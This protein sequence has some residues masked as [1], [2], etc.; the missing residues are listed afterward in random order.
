MPISQ[1]NLNKQRNS[2]AYQVFDAES[3]LFIRKIQKNQV[4][5]S[6]FNK[7]FLNLYNFMQEIF[8]KNYQFL[9]KN[10]ISML[11]EYMDNPENYKS[12]SGKSR[13]SSNFASLSSVST[14]CKK[15]CE[16]SADCSL[17]DPLTNCVDSKN[18]EFQERNDDFKRKKWEPKYINTKKVPIPAYKLFKKQKFSYT[19]M[20][21]LKEKYLSSRDFKDKEKSEEIG[22]LR[23]S[24]EE[25]RQND[26]KLP[27]VKK[28]KK[29]EIKEN[30]KIKS[31]RLLKEVKE[32]NGKEES[33]S[34]GILGLN[35]KKEE[36]R[37]K[38]I[39]TKRNYENN[40]EINRMNSPKARI[41]TGGDGLNLFTN[42][43]ARMSQKYKNKE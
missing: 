33:E 8:N 41:N 16:I 1:K 6:I 39:K 5:F 12:L 20:P 4:L 19:V 13:L 32:E 37:G 28:L 17:F 7:H 34:K 30:E 10:L 31:L 27:V 2:N 11:N 25:L 29:E 24:K 21:S 22:S 3:N 26:E 15:K 18:V 40:K 9:Y 35:L 42:F 38:S 43:K 14:L 36:S 23:E